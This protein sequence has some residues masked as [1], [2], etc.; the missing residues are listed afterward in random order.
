VISA[1]VDGKK[2]IPVRESTLTK[3]LC[4]SLGGNSKTIMIATISPAQSNYSETMSTLRYAD[5]AK[6][7]KN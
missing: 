1:I 4:N 2:V 7:I 6:H 5:H 3:L